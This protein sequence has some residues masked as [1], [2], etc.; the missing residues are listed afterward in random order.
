MG[1][2]Q[3]RLPCRAGETVSETIE[4]AAIRFEGK[5]WSLPK[6]ARHIDVFLHMR[7]NGIDGTY[8]NDKQGFITS[9]GRFV[10]RSRAMLIATK[11]EQILKHP[12]FQPTKLFSEDVW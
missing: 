8:G 11:A 10:S 5:T 6:P 2:V 9:T 12:T 7:A 3:S 1:S 4:A